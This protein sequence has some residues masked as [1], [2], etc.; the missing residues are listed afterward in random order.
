MSALIDT[1][2][3]EPGQLVVPALTGNYGER[4]I[5]AVNAVSSAVSQWVGPITV[6]VLS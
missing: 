5:Q 6:Q 3:D 1:L 2:G 4:Q